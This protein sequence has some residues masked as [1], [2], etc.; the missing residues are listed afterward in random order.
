MQLSPSQ[1]TECV[2]GFLG[3]PKVLLLRSVLIFMTLHEAYGINS[4]RV[5]IRR[6]SFLLLF[7][8]YACGNGRVLGQRGCQACAFSAWNDG[9]VWVESVQFVS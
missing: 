1:R 7:F 2:M 8:V 3:I 5:L 6:T 9:G 4:H